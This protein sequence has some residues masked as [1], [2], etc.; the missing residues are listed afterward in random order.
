MN[1]SKQ[2]STDGLASITNDS[3][4][5][6]FAPEIHDLGDVSSITKSV[7]CASGTDGGYS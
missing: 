4:E 3:R 5:E 6:Y 2:Q 1:N 7:G